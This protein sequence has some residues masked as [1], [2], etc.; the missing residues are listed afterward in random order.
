MQ[1]YSLNI[2]SQTMNAAPRFIAYRF[3]TVN[4]NVMGVGRFIIESNLVQAARYHY[5]ICI[6]CA[7]HWRLFLI[8][9]STECW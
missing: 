4:V 7:I 5:V 9:L 6:D 2:V 3:G 8:V 1:I